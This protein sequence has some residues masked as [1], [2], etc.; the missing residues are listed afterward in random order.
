MHFSF[1]ILRILMWVVWAVYFVAAVTLLGMRYL[2]LPRIDQWR[3]QIEDYT[4][5]AIGARVEIG[6]ISADW[7]GLNPRLHLSD[8]RVYETP[9]TAGSASAAAPANAA[10]APASA[11]PVPGSAGATNADATLPP[12][13]PVMSAPATPV[14]SLPNVQ[15]VVAWRSLFDRVPRLVNLRADG[16]DITLRRDRDNRLW[17]A[18]QAIALDTGNDGPWLD[19]AAVRWLARQREIALKHVT[20]RWQDELRGTPDLVIDDASLALLNGVLTHRFALRAKLPPAL[21]RSLDLRGEVERSLFTRDPRNPANWHGQVY[22][23]VVDVDP[24]AWTPWVQLPPMG[25]RLAARAWMQ[26]DGKRIGAVTADL[27]ARGVGWQWQDGGAAVRSRLA[28]SNVRLHVDGLPGDVWDSLGGLAL[29]QSSGAPAQRA[30]PMGAVAATPKGLTLQMQAQDVSANLPGV[31]QDPNITLD[32]LTLDGVGRR[33]DDGVLGVE[34]RQASLRNADLDLTL[35]GRWRETGKTLAGTADMTGK[36]ARL[37]M[38][39]LHG[40]LPQTVTAEARDWLQRG[41][42]AGDVRD[43]G[44]VVQGDLDDFPF[45]QD[46]GRGKFHIGGAYDGA[47]V[48]YAPALD[49]KHKGWPA[50]TGLK[51]TFAIDGAALTLEAA[52]GGELQAPA[53]GTVPVA[54]NG[55]KATIPNME[56]K[57]ELLLSAESSGPIGTYLATSKTSP[58]GGLLD[59]LL[60][61]ARGTGNAN[62]ALA[63]RVPLLDPDATKVDGT[64]SF[65]NNEFALFPQLP[66]VQQLRGQLAFTE[67]DVSARGL[68]GQFLGGPLRVDG[69]LLDSRNGLRFDGTVNGAA[70]PQLFR[71][72]SMARISGKTNY[73]A[74]L[75]YLKGGNIDATLESDLMGLALDMPAPIGKPAATAMPVKVQWSP[76]QTPGARNRVWLTGSVGQNINVLLERDPADRRAFFARGAV[77]ANQPASLPDKGFTLK[78]DLPELDADAWETLIDGFSPTPT[79]APAS[80]AAKTAA[81]RPASGSASGPAQPLLPPISLVSIKTPQLRMSGLTLNDLTLTAE[82]PIDMQWRV[83][84]QSRQAAGSLSW[85]EGAGNVAGKVTGRFKYLAFGDASDTNTASEALSKTDELSDIPAVDLHADSL[86][87]YGKDVGTLQVLGTNLERGRRWQLDKLRITSQDASLDAKGIWRLSGADRGLTV[88]ASSQFKDFGQLL[89]RLGKPD[90]MANGAGTASASLTWNDLPWT[91]DLGKVEGKLEFSLDKGRFV[92]VNSRT[93]RLL[94]LLSL[95]SVGRLARLDFNPAN[96]LKDGFPFDTIRGHVTLSK[97]IA[98]TEDYKVA[99][100]VAS[101]ILAGDTN[102]VDET[103]NLKAVVVPNLDASGAAVAT[104]FVNPLLGLGAFLGQLI[105]KHPL[106]SALTSEYAVTGSWNDP[107]VAPINNNKADSAAKAREF[108]EN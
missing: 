52:P 75:L 6:K 14:L 79:P 48:D 99:G 91:H 78:L 85:R 83:D 47:T 30:T 2:V 53:P 77:G 103:W 36:L 40:Y 13:G 50:V 107:K 61:D 97:G 20:V 74:R 102:I 11:A 49:S 67:Q 17:V 82:R 58:L 69:S 92:H 42:K 27:F 10:A 71:A 68:E 15:A 12:T 105:L 95:Q 5:Q 35:Q 34:L 93:A 21:G 76:A 8:V 89:G 90:T 60:D 98:H 66:P 16:L 44:I 88:E 26:V 4:S 94:E 23:E 55:I 56:H 65:D 41:L 63:L 80:S 22:G 25:G 38:S 3:P 57:A 100:P 86:R 84:I 72:K 108:I 32:Q 96:L 18:G 28:A 101:I 70:L 37:R 54:L 106:A 39:T 51:G 59:N 64:V 43:A 24:A 73:H 104:A 46:T 45:T 7:Y 1:K 19:T 31:L 81:R 29:T 9:D 62:L 87:L 33:G